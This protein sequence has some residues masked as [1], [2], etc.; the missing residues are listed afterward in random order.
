M[1]R[2]ARVTVTRTVRKRM[3]KRRSGLEQTRKKSRTKKM[4]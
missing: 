2:T 4:D 1:M 3:R